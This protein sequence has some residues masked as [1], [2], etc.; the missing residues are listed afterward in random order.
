MHLA[1]QVASQTIFFWAMVAN[2]TSSGDAVVSQQLSKLFLGVV[3]LP[4]GDFSTCSAGSDEGGS[5]SIPAKT[6]FDR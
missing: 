6:F 3:E 4:I 1:L 5:A 2:L